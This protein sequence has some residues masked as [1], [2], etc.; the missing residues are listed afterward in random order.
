[1]IFIEQFLKKNNFPDKEW[2]NISK[3]AKDLISHMLCDP[4]KRF[5]VM[6]VLNHSWIVKQVPNGIELL[7]FTFL[8]HLYSFKIL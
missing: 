7:S 8:N 2:K 3:E 6:E 1:M 4:D 5:N